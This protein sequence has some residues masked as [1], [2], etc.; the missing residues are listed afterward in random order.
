MYLT[1]FN[2]KYLDELIYM[3]HQLVDRLRSM[4]ADILRTIRLFCKRTIDIAVS[5]TGL[6][7][8]APVFALAALT[9]KLDSEG[10]VIF[11]QERVGKGGRIFNIY[12]L[13]TMRQD[14]EKDGPRW[15]THQH[16]T[17][18][19]RIGAFLRKSHI[20]ELPQLFNILKGDMS[21]V[22]PRPE[23]PCFVE[24][25]ER[26]IPHYAKRHQVKPGL[27]GLAQLRYKYDATIED[28]TR[29]LKYDLIY[30]KHMCLLLDLRIMA[31]TAVMLLFLKGI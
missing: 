6:V 30:V 22:G 23:R 20:D 21:L 15:A 5:F 14:A 1:A 26:E 27:T 24:T 16:D 12:K 19:T 2:E 9:I 17:R 25:F 7:V 29:K 10:P 13:R 31:R 11:S 4:R 28:V 18:I 8:S 3:A